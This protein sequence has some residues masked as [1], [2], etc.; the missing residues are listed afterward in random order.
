MADEYERTVLRH[1]RMAAWHSRRIAPVML[2]EPEGHVA[3]ARPAEP[4]AVRTV[5]QEAPRPH[6]ITMT[7]VVEP[8]PERTSHVVPDR[9]MESTTHEALSA[10]YGTARPEGRVRVAAAVESDERV[11]HDLPR[12]LQQRQLSNTVT[13]LSTLADAHEDQATRDAARAADALN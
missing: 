13:A 4:S 1:A 9:E 7:P 8:A 10:L 2:H 12:A 11:R 3:L 6:P 5:R